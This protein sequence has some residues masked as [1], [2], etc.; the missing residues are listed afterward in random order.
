MTQAIAIRTTLFTFFALLLCSSIVSAEDDVAAIVGTLSA[1]VDESES[2]VTPT[3]V[4]SSEENIDKSDSAEKLKNSTTEQARPGE[5]V[6]NPD[7]AILNSD[8]TL[9][10]VEVNGPNPNDYGYLGPGDMR[11]HLWNGHSNELIENGITENKLMAMTV[12]EVQKWHNHFHGVEGSPEHPHEDGEHS[13]HDTIVQESEMS[14]SPTYVDDSFEGTIVY[15]YSEY[16]DSEY[17]EFAYGQPDVFYDQGVIVE[18]ATSYGYQADDQ[19]TIIS[20]GMIQSET[21]DW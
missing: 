7:H 21:I 9:G 14:T 11:T 16:G 10:G 17:S 15:E 3:G 19:S 1:A 4:P 18:G 2:G 5:R 6:S 20:E 8:T 12:P 13:H